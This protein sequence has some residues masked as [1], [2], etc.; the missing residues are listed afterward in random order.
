MAGN[1]KGAGCLTLFA[2]L[3]VAGG[4]MQLFGYES[5]SEKAAAAAETAR[6]AGLPDLVGK[7]LTEAQNLAQSMDISLDDQGIGVVNSC[8]DKTDCLIFRMSPKP[9]T[10]MDAH[11]E[12]SVAWTTGEERAWYDKHRKM[13]KVVGWSEEKAERFFEPI[14]AAVTDSTSRESKNVPAGKHLVISQSPKAGKPLKLGQKI[15]LVIGYNYEPSTSNSTGS[16]DIDVHVGNGGESRFCSR[17]W[18]C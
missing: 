9:G 10:V 15:K 14:E 17:R 5:D 13:P 4:C 18:W 11:G 12:L 16:T 2:I 8:D 7:T 6:E 3:A 1:S